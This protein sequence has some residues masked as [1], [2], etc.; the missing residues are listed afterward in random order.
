MR[1]RADCEEDVEGCSGAEEAMMVGI[2]V[3]LGEV[4]QRVPVLR[5]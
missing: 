5:L 4:S 2:F 3:V 1:R